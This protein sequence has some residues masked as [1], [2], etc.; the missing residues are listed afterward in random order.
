MKNIESLLDLAGQHVKKIQANEADPTACLADDTL[1]SQLDDHDDTTS[2][3]SIFG[4]FFS[5]S[6]DRLSIRVSCAAFSLSLYTLASVPPK[7]SKRMTGLKFSNVMCAP[8]FF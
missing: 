1:C 5:P 6:E 2:F 4:M 8:N 7:F 3:E